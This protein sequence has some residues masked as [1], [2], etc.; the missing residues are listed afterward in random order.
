VESLHVVLLG[1]VKYIA[2][3]DISKLK[4]DQKLTLIERLQSFSMVSLNITSMKPA[5]LIKHIKSL[6]GRHFKILLQAAP[7]FLLEFLTPEKE[8]I[9]LALCNMTPLIFQTK[10]TNLES[11]LVDLK[12]HIDRFLEH[13]YWFANLSRS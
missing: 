12:L 3:E 7:F 8:D 4:A 11:Y 9:W 1:V 5:Y 6:V 10:I 2:R 13:L